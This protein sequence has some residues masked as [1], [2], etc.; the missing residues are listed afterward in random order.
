MRPPPAAVA[1]RDVLLAAKLHV[2]QPRP[3]FLPRPQLL[4]RLAEATARELVLV[5]TPAGFGKTSLLADWTRHSRS[6]VAWLSLDEA[7]NDPVKLAGFR[8]GQLQLLG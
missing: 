1:E 6:P 5:C 8:A 3:G 7:D 4:E 2:P